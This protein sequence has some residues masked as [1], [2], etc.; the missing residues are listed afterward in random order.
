VDSAQLARFRSAAT[1]ARSLRASPAD[2]THDVHQAGDVACPAWL[3][4]HRSSRP[5]FARVWQYPTG[6]YPKAM[7]AS[8]A[9]AEVLAS[10]V[11]DAEGMA[12]VATLRVLA[13][14]DPRAV[15]ALPASLRALR[16]RPAARGGRSVPQ[17]VIQPI[18]FEPSPVC[19]TPDAGPVCA[20]RY[21]TDLNADRPGPPPR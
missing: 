9:H 21:S 8:N 2:L 13:G 16:F 6:I 7:A 15:A 14:S 5:Q 11:V 12:D 20:R 10:F 17:R 3:P 1:A 4:W 19:P 18:L